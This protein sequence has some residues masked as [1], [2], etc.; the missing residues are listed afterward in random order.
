MAGKDCYTINHNIEPHT[1]KLV[2]SYFKQFGTLLNGSTIDVTDRN[3]FFQVPM[4]D[5]YS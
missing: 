5:Q 4:P 1:G 3:N 2:N